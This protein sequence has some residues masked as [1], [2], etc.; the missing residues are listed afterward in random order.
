MRKD[1]SV[2]IVVMSV[3]VIDGAWGRMVRVARV[4]VVLK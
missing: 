4:G 3:V 1:G 2:V